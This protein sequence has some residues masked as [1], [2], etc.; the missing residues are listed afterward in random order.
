MYDRDSQTA[1]T[2][3]HK[4]NNQ[5]TEQDDVYKYWDFKHGS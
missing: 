4:N 1:N 5:I 2:G 3:G